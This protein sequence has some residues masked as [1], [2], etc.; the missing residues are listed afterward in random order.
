MYKK[1]GDFQ[2]IDERT[3]GEEHQ[4]YVP[5]KDQNRPDRPDRSDRLF[6]ELLDLQDGLM[7]SIR[8]E[9][10]ILVIQAKKKLLETK[11]RKMSS[12]IVQV[13]LLPSHSKPILGNDRHWFSLYKIDF[14][15]YSFES[16]INLSGGD[17]IL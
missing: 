2:L 3:F 1:I 7:E 16:G 10:P 6:E 5:R 4:Y 17:C 8:K 11:Y 14:S 15:C 12:R 13:R 9:S